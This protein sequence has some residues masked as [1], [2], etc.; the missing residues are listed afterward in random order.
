MLMGGIVP[1][2]QVISNFASKRTIHET[3]VVL[4]S[5]D[6]FRRG[7]LKLGHECRLDLDSSVWSKIMTGDHLSLW[8]TFST[9]LSTKDVTFLDTTFDITH[10]KYITATVSST[11]LTYSR[12]VIIYIKEGTT[13]VNFLESKSFALKKMVAR[14]KCFNRNHRLGNN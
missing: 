13:R 1:I 12:E 6:L 2:G 7:L 14:P 9:S 4:T 3:I 8:G 10:E 5:G 11:R